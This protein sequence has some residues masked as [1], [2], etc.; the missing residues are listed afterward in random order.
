MKLESL[1]DVVSPSEDPSLC[2]VWNES[3]GRIASASATCHTTDTDSGYPIATP[4]CPFSC[5][6]AIEAVNSRREEAT[7]RSI[8]RRI[9]ASLQSP[10]AS[11]QSQSLVSVTSP[12]AR[13]WRLTTGT[14]DWD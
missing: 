9:I 10:V 1:V 14:D 3:S 7:A 8:M 5:A 11:G 12:D 4:T 6:C 13:G 2:V